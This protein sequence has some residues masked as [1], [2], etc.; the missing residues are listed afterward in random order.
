MKNSA[1][2]R[3]APLTI[4]TIALWLSMHP[5]PAWSQGPWPLGSQFQVN[6][7]TSLLQV[8]S[9]VGVDAAGN[10]VVV[11]WGFDSL[12]NDDSNSSIQG[13]RYDRVGDPIGGEFQVNSYTTAAQTGP[14]VAIAPDGRFVVA[15]TSN[16][17]VG[18][19]NLSTSIQAQRFSTAGSPVGG[20]FQVNTYSG[21]IQAS[22]RAAIDTDGSFIVVWRSNGSYGTDT[23]STSVQGQR[24]DAAGVA[25]GD[26]FQVNTY[27]SNSQTYPSIGI[28]SDGH[29]IVVW[30]SNGS[31]GTD[32]SSNS[33][34]AQRYDAAGIPVGDEF[35]VNSY[36]T[37]TQWNPSVAVGTEG[38]FVVAWWSAGSDGTDSDGY[39]VQARRFDA[40]GLAVGAEF[41]VNTYTTTG[42]TFPMVVSDSES[43]FVVTWTSYGSSGTDTDSS[44]IFAQ[45]FS[46]NGAR[47]GD[48]FQVNTYTTSSQRLSSIGG[49][50]DG[51]FVV[52]WDSYGSAGTDSSSN[53]IQAQH[54]SPIFADGF[55]TGDVSAWSN[56]LP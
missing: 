28:D 32:T 21:N 27:T 54:Y 48:E 6:T 7:S 24:Y 14:A 31:S 53:S 38:D 17:S 29:F 16:G 1:A 25:Q 37:G 55:E 44:S 49:N 3:F 42:Q 33:I 4:A 43:N 10:F 23:S 46:A 47:I 15:W 56:S 13:Q 2:S 40:D 22:P 36:T 8:G 19:D 30:H 9:S 39:S 45:S 50:A 12:G 26:E 11:W 41:Q 52:A 18:K 34:Q 20:Q 5:S 51:T 35:Q